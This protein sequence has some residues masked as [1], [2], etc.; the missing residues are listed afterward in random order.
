MRNVLTTLRAW[1]AAVA[2]RPRLRLAIQL[3]VFAILLGSLAY[4]V[5][6]SWSQAQESL[7]SA[8]PL[9]LLAGVAAIALYYLAFVI[10][11]QMIL[12]S[13][14]VKLGYRTV[15]RA[16][17]YSMLAKYVPGGVWT[18]AARVVAVRGAGVRDTPL[19]LGSIALEAGLSAVA[20]VLVFVAA[21]PTVNANAPS[22]PWLIGFAVLVAVLLHPRVFGPLTAR[23]AARTGGG[24]VPTLPQRVMFMLVAFYSLTWLIA[25]A[26]LYMLASSV[27]DVSA[28][29][30][31]YLG[32]VSAVGAIVAVLVVIAPSGLGAREGAMYGLLV[33]VMSPAT[34]L[35]TVVLNRLGITI[36]EAGLLLSAGVRGSG[37]GAEDAELP[38]PLALPVQPSSPGSRLSASEL[39]Q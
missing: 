14:G 38:D 20:G 18:P 25:G 1:A 13:M 33:A 22:L 11:W 36:V 34:A 26:A 16:E 3:I 37:P 10:G 12:A 39:M 30:I 21:L 2:A 6:D 24:V 28:T 8:Q 17:M 31:P 9:D 27:G 7:R 19:V 32:G 15:L 35:A 4:A 5:R 23:I 29:A